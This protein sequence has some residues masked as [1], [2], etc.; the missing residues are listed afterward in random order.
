VTA[1]ATRPVP[2]SRLAA[3]RQ[4][5]SQR[6]GLHTREWEPPGR[7]AGTLVLVHGLVVAGRFWEPTAERLADRWRVLVPDLPGYG[8]SSGDRPVTVADLGA[9]LAAWA[10][11]R[12]LPRCAWLA[13]SFGCQVL[14]ELALRRPGLVDRMVLVAPTL[15]PTARTLP[16]VLRRWQRESS[17]QSFRL[18]RLLVRDYARAGVRCAVATVRAAL[19]DRVEDRLPHLDV[20]TL[21][22]RGTADPLTPQGWAEEVTRLLPR[23]QLAV[24]PDAPHALPF[25]APDAL[26]DVVRPFL[27]LP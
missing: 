25:D 6:A 10:E 7:A 4:R 18:Q 13:G 27:E 8:R 16:A 26:A 22:V 21:V 2:G 11:A 20:P 12:N 19:D 23:A 9:A 3:A 15:D 24:V 17:T 14:T 1:V 5:S